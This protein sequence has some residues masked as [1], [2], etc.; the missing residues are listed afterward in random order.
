MSLKICLNPQSMQRAFGRGVW[1]CLSWMGEWRGEKE[2][3]CH[4]LL[5]TLL[6]IQ[7][8]QRPVVAFSITGNGCSEENVFAEVELLRKEDYLLQESIA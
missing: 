6:W 8:I 5:L 4:G 1:S 7:V 2:K 3:S